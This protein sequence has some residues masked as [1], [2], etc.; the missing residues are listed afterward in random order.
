MTHEFLYSK[1][2]LHKYI[3]KSNF[4]SLSREDSVCEPGD[5][6][7]L[8][9]EIKDNIPT[10]I[11]C[12]TPKVYS[13]M[14]TERGT[15]NE[16]R[17]F[18]VRGADRRKAGDVYRH[19]IFEKI[20]EDRQYLPPKT[21]SN[22]IRRGQNYGVNTV[23][24]QKT[25][26]SILDNKRY[27]LSDYKSYAYGHP[28]IYKYGYTDNDIKISGACNIKQDTQMDIDEDFF[29][30]HDEMIE[31]DRDNLDNLEHDGECSDNEF[32]DLEEEDVLEKSLLV[33][34]DTYNFEYE[35]EEEVF[36]YKY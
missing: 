30:N 26:L 17:K 4:N 1:T 32:L 2:I 22:H 10:D 33:N 28:E 13:I 3:D 36:I 5:L 35:E 21:I 16:E 7:Y 11:I 15:N 14:S 8:K 12:L 29:E 27:W 24:E 23:R 20:L 34:G 31:N 25:C 18:A 9:S 19:N 6:G